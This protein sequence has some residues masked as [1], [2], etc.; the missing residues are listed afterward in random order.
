MSLDGE[1]AS[2]ELDEATMPVRI[3]VFSRKSLDAIE[4]MPPKVQRAAVSSAGRLGA[5]ERAAWRD[6]KRMQGMEGVWTARIGIHH[7]MIFKVTETEL[8]VMD[9]VTREALLTSLERYR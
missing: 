2:E 6:V 1:V 4:E 8:T 5:G 3:P 9:V 7:R